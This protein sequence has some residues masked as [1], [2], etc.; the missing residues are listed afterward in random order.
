MDERGGW[1]PVAARHLDAF[2]VLYRTQLALQVHYRAAHVV[3]LLWFVLKPVLY[4]TIWAAVARSSEGQVGGLAPEDVAA[5][6]L[7]VMWVVHLTFN[8]AFVS[9]ESRVRRGDFSALLLRPV[10][11]IV[12]DVAE[13]LAYKTHTTP[14]LALATLV[15]GATFDPRIEPPLWALAAAVPAWLL[16]FALRFVTTWTVALSAFWLTRTQAVAQAYLLLLLFLGGEAAPLALLPDW[17]RA[18]AWATPFPWMLGFPAELLVG[19]LSPVEALAGLGMQ[20]LWVALSLFLTRAC[21]R[22]ALRR[23]TAAGA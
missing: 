17:V 21:W 9:F 7:A 3:W 16:A 6:F 5:Y 14:M 8:G 11:P 1:R 18:V 12:G 15:L 4:L 19:R 2:G 23:F 20:L 13:N 10:H 22:A